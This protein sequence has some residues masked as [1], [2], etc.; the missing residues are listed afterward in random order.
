MIRKSSFFVLIALLGGCSNNLVS[1][2]YL[3]ETRI[4]LAKKLEDEKRF[5]EALIQWRVL[6]TA[7]PYDVSIN[8]QISRVEL[9]IS[10]RL[11]SLFG[12]LDETK[13]TDEKQ[14]RKIYLKILALTPNNSIAMEEL[15][16]YE[17]QNALEKAVTKTET[18]KKY[19]AETQ[20]KAE[21]SIKLSN[22]LN[23]GEQL[24]Q[25]REYNSLLKL[26][27]KFKVAFP[28]SEKPTEFRLLAYTELAEKSLRNKDVK[29]AI[30]FFDKAIEVDKKQN[31]LLQTKNDRLKSKLSKKYMTLGLQAFKKDLDK[32]IDMFTL[33]L[34]YQPNNSAARQQLQRATIVRD[35]LN[36]IKELNSSSS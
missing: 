23:Q 3:K 28:E 19:F 25:D 13:S 36:K 2:D 16:E 14:K 34:K 12:Q 27:E 35:N 15:R 5:A 32:A 24:S 21:K 18:I 9:V 29:T 33:S 4:P 7:S 11:L 8:A 20:I 1:H 10:D 30:T 17:W 6:Q 31:K 22:F 26:A